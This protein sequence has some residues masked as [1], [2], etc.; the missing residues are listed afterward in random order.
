MSIIQKNLGLVSSPDETLP[1]F[2]NPNTDPRIGLEVESHFVDSALRAATPESFYELARRVEGKT[3]ISLEAA[4]TLFEVKN[5]IPFAPG[6]GNAEKTADDLITALT[7]TEG[8]IR[9]MG[10]KIAPH[11]ILPWSNYED[12]AQTHIHKGPN[13][14]PAAFINFFMANNPERARNFIT[15]AGQQSSL[16]HETPEDTLRYFNRL[17]HLTPLLTSVMSTVPP[18]A[19]LDNGEFG[20]VKTNL[21]LSRRLQTGGG[22]QNAFPG[23]LQ[24]SAINAAEAQGFMERWNDHVWDTPLFCYYD[25]SDE[26]EFTRLRHFEPSGT[27]VSFRNLPERLQTRENFNMASSIQY[28]LITM[29]HIPASDSMP[30]RRRAEAR[31]YDAGSTNQIRAVSSLTHAL[32][33]N[34]EFGERV[35][36]FVADR[37]YTEHRNPSVSLPAITD[38]LDHIAHVSFDSLYDLPY[39]HGSVADAAKSFSRDVI[40]PLLQEFPDLEALARQCDRGTSPALDQRKSAGSAVDFANRTQTRGLIYLDYADSPELS[41]F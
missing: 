23:L 9:E 3:S 4:S 18:Y 38:T 16:T 30:D 10:H 37:G 34:G 33:F 15:V 26:N 32:A 28:G 20:A 6:N 39:G 40:K 31:L 21:S 36:R 5:D 11:S 14:R 8:E 27:M 19:V 1:E 22:A 12:L 41:V 13:P 25:P 17:A 35:D 24:T 29:S 2:I 7:I